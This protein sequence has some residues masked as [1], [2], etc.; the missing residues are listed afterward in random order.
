MIKKYMPLFMLALVVLS[1]AFIYGCGSAATS[2]GGSSGGGV[3]IIANR[4]GSYEYSGTQSPGDMWT[5]TISTETF[6]GSDE[7]NG[8]WVSGTWETL[9]NKFCKAFVGDSS[10]TNAISKEAYF[11]EFPDTMLMIHPCDAN[12]NHK[13]NIIICTAHSATPPSTGKYVYITTPWQ[14][15][16]IGDTAYGSVDATLSGTYSFNVTNYLLTGEPESNVTKSGYI[17]T[18]GI[19]DNLNYPTD[20]KIFMTPSGV[21]MGDNGTSG[22]FAGA[23]VEAINIP[24]L[25]SH[26]YRGVRFVYDAAN[27]TNETRPVTAYPNGANKMIGREYSGGVEG[28]LDTNNY[29]GITFEAQNSSGIIPM[30]ITDYGAGPVT[31]GTSIY[32]AVAATVGSNNKY[33]L[34]GFGYENGEP[35]NFLVMQ[36]D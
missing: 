19:G 22:G 8:F 6:F 28:G 13:D 26:T 24:D 31:F 35:T 25:S 3:S 33:M 32:K 34:F 1:L 23:S 16:T 18:D 17:F 27:G 15:W 12:N 30:Y 4:S 11:L 2:G 5:W 7:S 20:P 9:S 36:V 21:F 10:D 14:G 29:V